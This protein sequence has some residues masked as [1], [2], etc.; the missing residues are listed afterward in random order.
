[1][2]AEQRL[3][4]CKHQVLRGQRTDNI[5]LWRDELT[6]ASIETGCFDLIFPPLA[7]ERALEEW[8]PCE[9]TGTWQS[10]AWRLK[11]KTVVQLLSAFVSGPMWA[12]LLTIWPNDDLLGHPA[13]V[14]QMA[15]AAS[16]AFSAAPA[17][18][19]ERNRML[20]ELENGRPEEYPSEEHFKEAKEWLEVAVQLSTSAE[21]VAARRRARVHGDPAPVTVKCEA[22]HGP[23]MAEIPNSSAR[24][25]RRHEADETPEGPERRRVKLEP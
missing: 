19:R 12:Y 23:S 2:P 9:C 18:E 20:F 1:M 7:P 17:S 11:Q 22:V 15:K 4:T 21:S 16:L 24:R 14:V 10:L 8:L 5:S 3:D 25:R 13:E 6:E